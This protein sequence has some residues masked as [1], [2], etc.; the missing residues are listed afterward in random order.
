MKKKIQI[1]AVLIASSLH[2]ST[3]FNKFNSFTFFANDFNYLI[4]IKFTVRNLI[5]YG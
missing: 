5:I 2:Q 1:P 3:I 4:N